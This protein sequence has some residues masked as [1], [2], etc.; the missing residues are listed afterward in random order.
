M[1]SSVGLTTDGCLRPQD[2]LESSSSPPSDGSMAL[3]RNKPGS[4]GHQQQDGL[5]APSEASPDPLLDPSWSAL[6]KEKR[7]QPPDNDKSLTSQPAG[8]ANVNRPAHYKCHT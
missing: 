3:Y 2:E 7:L 4:S 8:D 5:Q 6:D 1:I